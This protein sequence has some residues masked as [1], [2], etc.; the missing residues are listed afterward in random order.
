MR[1]AR[2]AGRSIP[3]L[4]F[5]VRLS[6]PPPSIRQLP[7]ACAEDKHYT[8]LESRNTGASALKPTNQ[9]L[10]LADDKLK[11]TLHIFNPPEPENEH[12]THT[13]THTH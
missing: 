6:K 3:Q 12:L 11:L 1:D 10:N 13:H 4:L 9:E 8:I 7:V 2:A 5:T